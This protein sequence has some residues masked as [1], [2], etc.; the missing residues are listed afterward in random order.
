[1]RTDSRHDAAAPEAG[2]SGGDAPAVE[3][4]GEAAGDAWAHAR[5]RVRGVVQGVGFRPFVYRIAHE[6]RLAGWVTN[7]TDGVLI[8]VQGAAAAVERFCR[9]LRDEPPPAAR[10]DA[11]EVEALEP[12]VAADAI[13]TAPGGAAAAPRFV[14]AESRAGGQITTLVSPDLP[15]C[16]DC[17]REMR[18]PTDRR[19]RYPFINCTNCGPRYSIIAD[20]PYDR[21]NTTMRGFT[22]C[23]ACATEYHDPADRRFHAQ[24]VACPVCGPELVLLDAEGAELARAEGVVERAAA[25]L[26]DGCILAVKGLGGYHLACDA[27]D[28]RAVAAL[29]TRKFRKEKPFAVM[30]ADVAA[31][32]GAV[33]LSDVDRALLTGR[34]RPVVLAPKGS[35]PLPDGLAPGL[36]DLGVMLPYT[37]LQHL[38]FD[39]GAPRLLVMTSANRSSEPIAY[40]DDEAKERLRGIADAFVVGTRPIERRVD[41]SVATTMAGRP[42]VMRRARGYA[43]APV[44]RS[45]RYA[46]PI[47]G[48][49]AG[50]KNTITLATAGQ[51]FTSQHLG[52]LEHYDA[53]VA[54]EETVRDLARLYHV[55]PERATVV[56]DLHPDYPSTR[57]GERLAPSPTRVQH[58]QAH[59]ASVLAEREAF[60][61]R[62]LGFA[63]DGAG[64]GDDGTIWGGE[65][66]HGSLTE[67]FARVAH[68]AA[69]AL[70]GGDAAARNPVQAAVGFLHALPAE[71]W[72]TR[73]PEL[74]VRVASGM[75]ASRTN[76]PAT[77]SVGR[78]FDTVAALCGFHRPMSYEGQAAMWLEGLARAE[79][80]SADGAGAGRR[81]A[82]PLPFDGRSFD[83]ARL[84]DAVLDDLDAGA[85]PGRVAL[86]F[87]LAVAAAVAEAAARLH[88]DHPAQAVVLSGGVWQNR[89][90]FE[91]THALLERGGFDVWWN[92]RVPLGDGGISLGQVA[93][94]AARRT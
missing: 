71:R 74:P 5:V 42:A 72:Q 59:V 57:F 51:A 41:D 86:R 13:G 47:L 31:L 19:Y 1:M 11:V 55:D 81:S 62:V 77:T 30:A 46:A 54:F 73:L 21:P 65:V 92:Q 44:A 43:P 68:L 82:Y 8:D 84:L 49:G 85:P 83:H 33:V 12:A 36:V 7:D 60:E 88:D 89:L 15:V 80:A 48:L 28:A 94:A 2:A 79:A 69:A 16:D 29:R 3:A 90:L 40:R 27:A 56:V 67:G 50:L 93:W 70:P 34:E 45:D 20:L 87:H 14:I 9:R 17:L 61:T 66:F 58:H 91:R 10:V 24:P 76:T 26:A 18:D 35:R 6:D 64:L 38:L 78:L 4:T 22:L 39:A 63:F 37:P 25:L 23:E 52:D 75:I 32:D 53:Y